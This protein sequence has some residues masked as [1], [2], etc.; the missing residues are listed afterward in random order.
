MSYDFNYLASMCFSFM[1]QLLSVCSNLDILTRQIITLE[2]DIIN[3][4]II[5]MCDNELF[6]YSVVCFVFVSYV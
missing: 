3:L 2:F 5:I 6:N 1:S 4:L